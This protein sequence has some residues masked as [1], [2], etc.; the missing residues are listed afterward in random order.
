[1]NCPSIHLGDGAYASS[2]WAL[3]T[4]RLFSFDLGGKLKGS[5][6]FFA[7]ERLLASSYNSV[8]WLA[9]GYASD[10]Y[11]PVVYC[12]FFTHDDDPWIRLTPI[13]ECGYAPAVLHDFTR[14]FLTAS[15]CPWDRRQTDNWFYDCLE[16]G[17]VSKGMRGI[18]HGAVSGRLGSLYIKA[19]RKI[20]QSLRIERTHL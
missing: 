20:D 4:T 2:K 8:I 19:T 11:S 16:V 1:M 3:V 12:P 9:E 14:Q 10:G 5:Y 13:P 18:Y 6:K 7:G 15:G 17:G